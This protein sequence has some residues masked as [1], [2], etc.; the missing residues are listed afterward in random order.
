[1]HLSKSVVCSSGVDV[2]RR[3]GISTKPPSRRAARISIGQMIELNI[4]KHKAS[5]TR[6]FSEII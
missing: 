3:K 5:T 2:M 4:E 6:D 1:M